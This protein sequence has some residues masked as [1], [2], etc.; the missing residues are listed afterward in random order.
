MKALSPWALSAMAQ[1]KNATQ[2]HQTVFGKITI[3]V[4]QTSSSVWISAS[5]GPGDPIHF[6]PCTL[7]NGGIIS[8]KTS[9]QHS[10][11]DIDMETLIGKIKTVIAIGADAFPF[12]SYKTTLTPKTDLYLPFSPRDILVAQSVSDTTISWGELHLSQIGTRSGLVYFTRR[13]SML[14]VL[15]LQNLTALSLYAQQTGTSLANVVSGEMPEIGLSL[16]AATKKPLKKG[17]AVVISDS[18]ISLKVMETEENDVS[19]DYLD[20]L[21]ATYLRMPRPETHYLEWPEI[22][23]K[24]LKDLTENPGCWAMV[25][26]NSYLNA[27]VSDYD[28]PPEIMVQLAVLL[29]LID[30][31]EWSGESLEVIKKIKQ[32][33][34]AF[35]SEAL[36]TIL[37]W[38]PEAE[39]KLKGDEE[40]KMPM[41]M[42]SW[43]LHHPLLNLSRLALKGDK[44]A[45]KLFLNSIGYAIKVAHTFKYEWPVFYK[46]DT[47][48]VIKAE[49][50]DGEG[51]EQDVPGLYAH[52]MLQAYELTGHK[53]YLMEAEKAAKKLDAIGMKIMYQANNTAF[54]S[55]AL[56]RLYKITGN[57]R[58]LI[59]SYRCLA[60]IFQNVQL[61]DCN[62]GFGVHVPT[63][64]ALF[65]LADAPY[66]AAYEEQEVFC[67]MHD[68]L[69]HAE[70]VDILPSVRLLCTEFIRYLVER[71]PYYYPPMLPK[72][73]ISEEVKTGE[74]DAKL[75]IALE[76]I[77]DGN[78]QSGS[79]GQ[80][81]YGAGNAFGI[82]PRHFIRVEKEPFFIFT[83]YPVSALK[84]ENQTVSFHLLGD[85]R[86]S[87]C[88]RIV[89]VNG[90]KTLNKLNF[91]LMAGDAE[92][93]AVKGKKGELESQLAGNAK[94]TISWKT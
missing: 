44:N 3:R 34:P 85:E 81:V 37:R 65:P 47:L 55:G 54:A 71:A 43:Y 27:Y 69:K 78:M 52:V 51:G 12:I 2:L 22:L 50:A 45:K 18:F 59:L 40:Q 64:F 1:L 94:V 61:W 6:N 35:Y 62:Y 41:V 92:L 28:T 11:I 21:A 53:K 42:D 33:L 57:E 67:A 73:M 4:L 30:Y 9:T 70:G 7:E 19:L 93:Q 77:Q 46:M 36:K 48:E 17:E 88:M 89:P 75:W 39:H 84:H 72:E 32:G 90:I 49:T 31:A 10:H 29:P 15:Y 24:G 83:D 66:T 68:Y 80:E 82:L 16:P 74:I 38:H 20:L 26:G 58:Y 13:N 79:V 14:R 8:L 5:H 87:C 60:S 76:D 23:K 56:L 86:I 25:G 91:I 63:F